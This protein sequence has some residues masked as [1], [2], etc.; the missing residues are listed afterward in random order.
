MS[1]RYR[2][3]GT[4]GSWSGITAEAL[5]SGNKSI[6]GNLNVSGNIDCGGGIALTGAN[7]FHNTTAVSSI[8][9]TNTYINFKGAGAGSDWCYIR[10]IGTSEA[11]KLALDF[12]DDNNDARF[13]IRNVQSSVAGGVDVVREVF[14][15]DNGNVGI[16]TNI[17]LQK[18]HIDTGCLFIT[19]NVSNPGT[20]SSAS[21]WNQAGVGPTISGL[22]FVVQTNGTTERLRIDNNGLLT[23]SSNIDCGGGIA[24]TGSTAFYET[25]YI[26]AG[27]LTNTYINFKGAGAVNDWCYLRQI[28]GNN[29]YKLAF[30]FHDDTDDARFCIRKVQSAGADPDI[31][32]EV[33]TV[34]NGNVSC[35]GTLTTGNNLTVNGD[36]LY[37]GHRQP[38]TI[39]YYLVSNGVDNSGY[40]INYKGYSNVYIKIMILGRYGEYSATNIP[41]NVPY[42][43]SNVLNIANIEWYLWYFTPDS[44]G[45]QTKFWY[46]RMAAGT[47]IYVEEMWY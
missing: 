25:G 11:Y 3:A 19:N 37:K 24:I 26:N 28:G 27:N 7:A 10:Q 44:E 33:F 12:H 15:V 39:R 47:K 4:W 6:T 8:N 1:V 9:L 45:G 36:L 32:S 14:T 42:A 2:E 23:T 13:C 40:Y 38:L 30:D 21:L 41:T 20:V 46:G 17:P 43:P 35:T 22:Q 18:L 5:T 34:D 29:A 31:I 16:G